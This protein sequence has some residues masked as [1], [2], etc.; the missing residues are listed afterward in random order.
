MVGPTPTMGLFLVSNYKETLM[1]FAV[2]INS[3]KAK[4]LA[5]QFLRFNAVGI[6]TVVLGVV[7][8]F[9][10][11]YLGFNYVL[12]L[13]GDY[14]VGAVFSYFAN[15]KFTFKVQ[16]RSN[17]APILKTLMTYGLTLGLNVLLLG[18]AV[19]VCKLN[20]VLSQLVIICVLA[21]LNFALFKWVVFR[22]AL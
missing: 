2:Q 15:K 19:E 7:V 16:V 20:I 21:T 10:M 4:E 11:I 9:V 8:F 3:T 13:V 12:A 5:R 6:L 22:E 1:D 18:L 14:V 17:L